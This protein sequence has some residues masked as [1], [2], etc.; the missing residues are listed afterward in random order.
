MSLW[1]PLRA[2][3]MPAQI[4]A[5]GQAPVIDGVLDD[6]AWAD[7]T[8]IGDLRQVTPDAGAP[9][10]APVEM[11]VLHH[12]EVLYLCVRAAA[13]P[14]APLVARLS[15]R[16]A[17]LF[18]DDHVSL[19]LD[20]SGGGRNGYVFRVNANG[21]QQDA[22]IFDGGEEREDWDAI[23][24]VRVQVTPEGWTAELAIP[25]SALSGGGERPWGLNVEHYRAASGERVRW[26]AQQADRSVTGLREAG[27]LAGIPAAQ[28]GLGLR[29]KPSLRLAQRRAEGEKNSELEPG[30]DVFWR[31][32]PDTTASLTLNT[33]FAESEVDDRVVNLTRF[34]IFFPEKRE[35]F[36]QDAGVFAFGGVQDDSLPFFSRRIGLSDEGE[37][38]SLD[39]GAK[40]THES[41]WLEAGL[42]AARV[43]AGRSSDAANVGV[44]RAAVRAGPSGRIGV[45]GTAGNPQGTGGSRTWGVDYQYRQPQFLDAYI[46]SFD[47]WT[48]ATRNTDTGQ[49]RAHGLFVDW[50][51]LGWTGNVGVHEVEADYAPALGFVTETG[52]RNAFGEIGYWWR[53]ERGGDV[54]PQLDWELREG[55]DDGRRY[56]SL[57]PEVFVGNARDDYVLPEL[58]FE[59]ETL[60][61]D[62][63]IL[64]GLVIP[65]GDYR[66]DSVLIYAG[67]GA[68][69]PL[70]GE[71]VL[72]FGEFYDGE[73]EDYTLALSL[74]PHASWGLSLRGERTDL[75]LP[76]GDG[77]VHVA[78]FGLDVTP[79][80]RLAAS[81]LAQWDDVSDEVG[82]S[83][84]LR[85]T[86]V[87][88]RDLFL[89][90][91]RLFQ[92]EDGGLRTQARNETVKLSWNWQW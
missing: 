22:L 84:R 87:P 42:L 82:L 32:R 7:A 6:A 17:E 43:E 23:W 19:V 89:S 12:G 90:L 36:L 30:L 51:N 70:S 55:T 24:D 2:Q 78:A 86:P 88:G 72:R 75:H 27:R 5:S 53:T 18:G 3:D 28:S 29:V 60:I 21:A 52:V 77:T 1:A 33:D 13:T 25:L 62:F 47:A 54:I 66:Y 16:D 9:P 45:I 68:Q 44:A 35:F 91:N 10:T 49:G 64:P 67:I 50:P 73:R 79:S 63:E 14:Q 8:V 38:L 11:R 57:N 46:L 83:L 76:G 20:P 41:R 71:A 31:L 4:R 34:P 37:P 85:W 65:A 69:S 92:D 39:A 48:Q 74:R 56:R 15:S 80:P 58:F 81:T 40:L 26:R 59:R 61:E